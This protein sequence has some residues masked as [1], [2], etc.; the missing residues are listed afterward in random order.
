MKQT[1][2]VALWKFRSVGS[3][4]PCWIICLTM[5]DA[6]PLTGAP[7][8]HYFL[9]ICPQAAA[10]HISEGHPRHWMLGA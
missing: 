7:K 10:P 4:S 3:W 8:I 9:F 1:C 5:A 6:Q 2:L